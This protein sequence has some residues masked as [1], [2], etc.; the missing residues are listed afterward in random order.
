MKAV[1]IALITFLLLAVV[2]ATIFITIPLEFGWFSS[3]HRRYSYEPACLFP[4]APCPS[5][6]HLLFF[7]PTHALVLPTT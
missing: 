1:I 6:Q 4:A 7:V 2:L 3:G 5:T